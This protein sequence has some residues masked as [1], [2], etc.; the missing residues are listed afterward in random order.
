MR[1]ATNAKG[2]P[3]NKAG[4]LSRDSCVYDV[5]LSDN[6]MKRM[7]H[8]TIAQNLFVGANSEGGQELHFANIMTYCKT[9]EAVD[10]SNAFHVGRNGNKHRKRMTKGWELL[11]K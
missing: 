8:N 3:I 10:K 11:V 5:R 6:T 7:D 9:K 2:K 1:R 4:E